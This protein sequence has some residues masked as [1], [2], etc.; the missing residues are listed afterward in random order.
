MPTYVFA[1]ARI[2]ELQETE[3]AEL[4]EAAL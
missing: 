2:V 4:D 1:R 3:L